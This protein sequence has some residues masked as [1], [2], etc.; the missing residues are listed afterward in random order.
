MV[1]EAGV[2]GL[3]PGP[4]GSA[5]DR[6][7]P[8]LLQPLQAPHPDSCLGPGPATPYSHSLSDNDGGLD[9][10]IPVPGQAPGRAGVS[11]Q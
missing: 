6:G 11:G 8:S 3:F 2:C 7:Q 9:S 5:S 4:L 10:L 1:E